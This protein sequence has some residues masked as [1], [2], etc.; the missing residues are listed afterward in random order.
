MTDISTDALIVRDRR[1]VYAGDQ[2][3]AGDL[4]DWKR[5]GADQ[6]RVRQIVEL[7]SRPVVVLTRQSMRDALKARSSRTA[8]RGFT[9]AG[10]V[11]Q[12]ILTEAG[13]EAF[14]WRA[15]ADPTPAPA[16]SYRPP[17]GAE[18]MGDLWIVQ[19]KTNGGPARFDIFDAKGGRVNP[20][21]TILGIVNARARAEA[22][23][24]R[25]A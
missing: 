6:R 3:E 15:E 10:L 16:E 11:A 23:L 20:G 17:E 22:F 1:W 9:P 24:Q 14:G 7:P 12:G 13:V 2:Y 25:A 4:F 18:A 19:A 5:R 21:G 8:P